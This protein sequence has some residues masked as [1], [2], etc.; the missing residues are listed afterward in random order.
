[1]R[2]LFSRFGTPQTLVTDNGTPFNSAEFKQFVQRNDI[3]HVRTVPYHPASN[4]LA[5]RAVQTVEQGLLKQQSGTIRTQLAR[6]SLSYHTTPTESMGKRPAK[7]MFGRKLRTRLSLVSR[8]PR[9]DIM[10]KQGKMKDRYEDSAKHRKFEED[11][12]VYTKLPREPSW[13]KATYSGLHVFCVLFSGL[14][15]G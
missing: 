7:L 9:A 6:F 15:T 10:E 8:E 12:L 11:D 5:E 4:G 14:T 1:M 3:R 2:I 13:E